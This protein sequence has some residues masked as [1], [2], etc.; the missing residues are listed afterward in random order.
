MKISIISVARSGSRYLKELIHYHLP[1]AHQVLTE[2][3]CDL[4]MASYRKSYVQSIIDK[5]KLT[6]NVL[7]KSHINDYYRINDDSQREYFFGSTWFKILLLR[8]N[9]FDCTLSHCVALHLSNFNT[10]EY[11]QCNITIEPERFVQ[12]IDNKILHYESLSQ[13]KAS[14]K[15]N[16]ILYY[17]DLSFGEE[18]DLSHFD[19]LSV[20]SIQNVENNQTPSHLINIVNQEELYSAFLAKVK[21]YKSPW[22]I[23][24]NGYFMLT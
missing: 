6:N 17:E 20:T 19:F 22:L 15:Y 9:L 11:H 7:I 18:Q 4:R 8:K 13:L 23:N 14:N 3:F 1:E 5:C 21:N 16:K 12:M 2:P 24:D 10:R